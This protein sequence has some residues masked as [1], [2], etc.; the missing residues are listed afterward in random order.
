MLENFKKNYFK[1]KYQDYHNIFNK[2]NITWILSLYGTAIGAGVL[3]LPINIGIGG[4]LYL[5]ILI[6]IA[7]PITFLSHRNLARLVLLGNKKDSSI[8]QVI[9]E[10]FGGKASL[11]F[12]ILYF[13]SIYPILLIYSTAITNTVNFFIT[14]HINGYEIPRFILASFLIFLLMF[15]ILIG[16]K[17]IVKFMSIL[18]FPFILSLL[19][20]SFYLIQF[21]NF[22][23]F[24]ELKNFFHQYNFKIY[25]AI[26]NLIPIIIFSFNHSPIISSFVINKKKECQIYAK[27]ICP[28][29]LFY[30]HILMT[31]TVI[32]FVCSCIFSITTEEMI[33]AKNQNVSILSYFSIRFQ[34]SF[35]KDFGPILATIAITKSFLGH[36]IGAKEGL[37]NVFVLIFKKYNNK[38]NFY[39]KNITINS[40]VF[41]SAWFSAVFNP[42]ILEIIEYVSGPIIAIILFLIPTY[43]IYTLPSMQQY[44]SEKLINLFLWVTGSI[45]F[46]SIIY[47]LIFKIKN[48]F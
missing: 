43:A 44:R 47:Q 25:H 42:S 24:H 5:L 37:N 14:H 7:F 2:N 9:D 27:K 4:I 34:N 10:N 30:S 41:I 39:I 38:K 28:R 46:S 26:W 8:S 23:I 16:E 22:S 45:A 6:I 40:I 15:I 29:I 32:F 20:L 18:V 12:S 1:K 3:F 36:Y 21:W 33:E 48:W 17:F 11:L 13:L 19:F 31:T 35:L